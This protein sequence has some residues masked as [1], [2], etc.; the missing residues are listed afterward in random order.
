MNRSLG[1]SETGGWKPPEPAGRMPAL[2][3]AHFKSI[4]GETG[5]GA[6]YDGKNNCFI[7]EFEDFWL[8]IG[9]EFLNEEIRKSGRE[10]GDF[11]QI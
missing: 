1:G 4:G 10:P 6:G 9:N 8:R 11:P 5:N 7:G 2:G 3:D